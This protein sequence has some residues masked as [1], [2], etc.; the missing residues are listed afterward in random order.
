M[1][2]RTFQ[3]WGKALA[4][5]VAVHPSL[6]L[7]LPAQASPEASVRLLFPIL[8]GNELERLLPLAPD[9]QIVTVA[10]NPFIQLANFY[11]A[12]VAHQLGRSIQRR[13]A[14]PFDLAYDPDHPQLQLALSGAL[15]AEEEPKALSPFP[16]PTSWQ[17]PL[18]ALLP[19]SRV[20]PTTLQ[21]PPPH[22]PWLGSVAIT[23]LELG[24]PIS[25][26]K[27]AV[28]DDI[29]YLYVR[30]R[31]P[32][33]INR[34]QHIL[35]IQELVQEDE[36]YLARVGVFTRSRWGRTLIKEKIAKLQ[37][38][39]INPIQMGNNATTDKTISDAAATIQAAPNSSPSIAL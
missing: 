37:R 31:Q 26:A 29:D 27:A 33:K 10:G 21:S 2:L 25:R 22:H 12:R 16:A 4:A 38:A 36:G 17:E 3:P 30:V 13:V 5:L 14:I 18:G 34:L 32:I 20:D 7:A 15:W 6:H 1:N 39:G 28:N 9:A 11:D 8:E 19:S 24:V 23:A 35:P